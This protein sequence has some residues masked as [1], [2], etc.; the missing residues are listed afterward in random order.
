MKLKRFLFA[1]CFDSNGRVLLIH[2]LSLK[3]GKYISVRMY[4][5]GGKLSEGLFPDNEWKRFLLAKKIVRQTGF[6]H[7]EKDGKIVPIETDL[8]LA[9]VTIGCCKKYP[10]VIVGVVGGETVSPVGVLDMAAFYNLGDFMRHVYLKEV[11]TVQKYLILGIF[12]S[13]ENPNKYERKEAKRH[14][15]K[16]K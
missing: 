11:S 9:P 16:C 15:K 2:R 7:F 8:Q 14:L 10:V 4:L 1:G 12:A 13:K 5:P 6:T 3:R